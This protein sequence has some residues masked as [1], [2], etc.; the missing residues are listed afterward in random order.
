MTIIESTRRRG[1]TLI[2]LLV[3]IGIIG[4]LIGLLLPAVQAA[5]EAA[6]RA[7]CASRQGQLIQAALSFAATNNGFP[8]SPFPG[9][10]PIQGD[11]WLGFYSAQCCLAP[12]LE[13]S[14]VFN[15]INFELP[16]TFVS[17]IELFQRTAASHRIDVFLCPSDPRTTAGPLAPNSFRACTGVAE[18][19]WR[20]DGEIGYELNG[21]FVSAGYN[22]P[23]LS[24]SSFRDGMS[25]TLAFSEKPIGSGASGP[26]VPFRDWFKIDLPLLTSD[27][28]IGLCGNASPI[29]P[30]FDAGASW[31]AP[32]AIYT[33]FFA[34]APPDTRVPDCGGMIIDIGMGLYSA[35]SYH[36]GGVNAAMADGSVRW[37]SSS[38]ATAAWRS[39][40]TRAGGEVPDQ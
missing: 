17:N 16:A 1:M 39:L 15:S 18:L 24:L 11:P 6:R 19:R 40:G 31:M 35:R 26:Y 12:F 28:W 25:N 13:Q 32:G 9:K 14:D 34:S 38:I 23:Y 21:A 3:V 30:R 2:E 36:P 29:D 27:Q 33:H 4:L 8:P 22:I 7:Q 37:F 20:E 5:R 10:P